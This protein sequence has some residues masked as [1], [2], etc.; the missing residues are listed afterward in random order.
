MTKDTTTTRTSR[1]TF[2]RNSAVGGL[3]LIVLKN[4]RSACGYPANEQLQIAVIGVGGRGMG[5][6]GKEGWSSVQAEIGGRIAALCD[7]NQERAARAFE[8]HPDVPKTS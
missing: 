3:G 7:V 1:R 6:V 5:F 8:L 4:S 2:L